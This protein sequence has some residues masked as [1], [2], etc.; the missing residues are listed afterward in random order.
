M[1][2]AHP[3]L[4]AAFDAA[5]LLPAEARARVQQALAAA[6]DA[7]ADH[8]FEAILRAS[9][10]LLAAPER[11]DE[12]LWHL[13]AAANACFGGASLAALPELTR[14]PELALATRGKPRA[15]PITGVVFRP[16][17]LDDDEDDDLDEEDE[18]DEELDLDAL[19]D[20]PVDEDA[21]APF[22]AE[23]D[24]DDAAFAALDAEVGA[25]LAA[26]GANDGEL[27]DFDAPTGVITVA[28]AGHAV[29]FAAYVHEAVTA[30]C[31]T[32]AGLAR[33]RALM[34]MVTRPATE[35]RILDEVD[36]VMCFGA[37]AVA[38]L[39]AHAAAARDELTDA[40]ALWGPLFALACIEGREA[41]AALAFLV[42]RLAPDDLDGIAVA[43]EA[44]ALAPHPDLGKLAAVLLQSRA[45]AA[46]ALALDLHARRHGLSPEH[47]SPHLDDP[48]AAVVHAALRTLARAPEPLAELVPLLRARARH[49]S[50]AVSLAAARLLLLWNDRSAYEALRHGEALPLATLPQ[51]LELFVMGGEDDDLP[52]IER[53]VRRLGPSAPVLDAIGRFGHPRAWAYLAHHL[54]QE[55]HA[56]GAARALEAIFGPV[57]APDD[58]LVSAAWRK[59][60]A[61]AHFDER[62]R[63]RRG[64]PWT[65]ESVLA[66]AAS[67][68]ASR[69]EAG[70]LL[71]ELRARARLFRAI[72]IAGWSPQPESA[73]AAFAVALGP[74][75]RRLPGGRWL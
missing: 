12:V 28:A 50:P 24:P 73:L 19:G 34:P 57:V 23:R 31:D 9:H 61:A 6:F 54:D 59:A 66:A 52:R 15:F 45:P 43:G 69:L 14:A 8:V 67:G 25:A 53:L 30:A 72:D 63:Y 60:L 36:A 18:E 32:L 68:T 2:P 55:D 65:A 51:A 49:P 4:R 56:S 58:E 41:L 11:C 20:E 3:S 46:R 1:N 7:G 38:P 35:Q 10:E 47:L 39:V 42:E 64:Q 13:A 37:D 22:H 16:P 33:D 27:A 40:W 17:R 29:P 26:A 5:A 70:R 21:R 48:N 62:V 71:D 74:E 75:L 44:L